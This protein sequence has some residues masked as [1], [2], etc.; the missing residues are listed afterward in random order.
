MIL[1]GNENKRNVRASQIFISGAIYVEKISIVFPK[2]DFPG[3]FKMKSRGY[4]GITRADGG[5]LAQELGVGHEI[6][7][8]RGSGVGNR[9][10]QVRVSH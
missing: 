4:A 10:V 7:S 1:N 8:L 9:V 5:E 2:N 6:P 3:F